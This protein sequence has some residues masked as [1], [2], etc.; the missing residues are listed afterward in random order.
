MDSR[1][2]W[3]AFADAGYN[4]LQLPSLPLGSSDAKALPKANDERKGISATR[5]NFIKMK[6]VIQILENAM[7]QGYHRNTRRQTFRRRKCNLKRLTT[8]FCYFIK[9]FCSS[10]SDNS[11]S[12]LRTSSSPDIKLFCNLQTKIGSHM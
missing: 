1:I 3:P 9:N 6:G 10:S 8:R 2:S 5:T 7:L 11:Y 12:H 4:T